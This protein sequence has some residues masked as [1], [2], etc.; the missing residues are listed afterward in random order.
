MS[1]RARQ[2]SRRGQFAPHA[3]RVSAVRHCPVCQWVLD[4]DHTEALAMHTTR[5]LDRSRPAAELAPEQDAQE[6]AA[7]AGFAFV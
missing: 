5:T 7:V 4:Q 6:A 3:F 1:D 2:D